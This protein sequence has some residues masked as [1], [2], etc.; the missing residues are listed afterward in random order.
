M[1][2]WI[3]TVTYVLSVILMLSVSLTPWL[4][5]VFPAW[6]FLVSLLILISNYRRSA[7]VETVVPGSV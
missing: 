6:V 2:R 7:E 1:P 5:I 4:A 3:A